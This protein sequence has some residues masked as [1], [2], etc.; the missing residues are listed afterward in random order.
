MALLLIFRQITCLLASSDQL[1]THKIRSDKHISDRQTVR[2]IIIP[3]I[4]VNIFRSSFL[5]LLKYSIVHFKDLMQ[6]VPIHKLVLFAGPWHQTV[7]EILVQRCKNMIQLPCL[8]FWQGTFVA[9]H[10]P[11]SSVFTVNCPKKINSPEI[12]EALT[13][14]NKINIVLE[15]LTLWVIML[16]FIEICL[17]CWLVSHLSDYCIS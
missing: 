7:Q 2:Q 3:L 6:N 14:I 11:L 17:T 12:M 1:L 10:P 4:Q 8:W 9:C 13:I 5:M 15:L 16:H